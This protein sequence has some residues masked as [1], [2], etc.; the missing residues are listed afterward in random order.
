MIEQRLINII[1]S[2]DAWAFVGSG[3]S[4]DAGL[5]TWQDLYVRVAGSLMGADPRKTPA[6]ATLPRSFAQ[7]MRQYGR[8]EVIS[9]VANH[10]KTISQPGPVHRLL[11]SLPFTAYVTTN[12][13]TLLDVAL[14][15]HPAWVSIGNTPS[16][17]R[18]ISGQVSRVVWHPHGI[19]NTSDSIS[20]LILSHDDYDATYPAGS[21]I[22]EALKALLRMRPIVFVGFGF[23]DPD[24][25]HL[26]EH[27]ARLSDPG[28]P[29]YAFLSESTPARCDELRTKYN[30][31]TIPYSASGGD[32]SELLTIL[33]HY[34]IFIANRN[35][36]FGET[37]AA[38]PSYDPEVTSLIVQNALHS[39]SIE[40]PHTTR[41]RVMRASVLAA[42]ATHG[43]LTEPDLEQQVRS[44][45]RA[46]DNSTF[47]SSLDH[48]LA[49]NL[50]ASVRQK[51]RNR[52]I[53]RVVLRI[54]SGEEC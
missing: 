2:R 30:V 23:N 4:V 37:P 39:G 53:L 31:V 12:Y 29:A 20:R 50:V 43:P 14:Q 49:A 7:L 9:Q 17:T 24:L 47:R 36:T 46:S 42:L 52:L 44:G 6:P 16:E 45:G 13:D 11:A 51:T 22:L 54:S 26:L 34:S 10:L 41:E 1:N 3:A 48:L 33:R 27:V 21:P 15:A 38:P 19:I 35:I 5:P 8:H 32:H 40:V 28:Q 18:K 25:A